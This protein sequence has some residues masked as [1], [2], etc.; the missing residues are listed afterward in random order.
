[1]ER[2]GLVASIE[3]QLER[4][5]GAGLLPKDGKLAS[6]QKMARV[7]GVSRTTIREALGRLAAR[8]LVVRRAGRRTRAVAL[9]EAVTL[10]NLG[11]ALHGEGRAHPDRRRLLE[12][13][14]ALKREA[15]VELLAACR[16]DA[17]RFELQGLT[18][19]CFAL[20]DAAR[21]EE[22]WVARE[23][24]LLRLAARVA[25]RPGH[26][27]LIQSLERA[28]WG[29]RVRVRPHLDAQAVSQWA[30]RALQA[31][32]E[33]EPA[34]LRRELEPLLRACDE[35][36]LERLAPAH[37]V[38]DRPGVS[39]TA[40]AERSHVETESAR[41]ALPGADCANLSACR[42]GSCAVAPEEV[43]RPGTAPTSACPE[44]EPGLFEACGPAA[45][46]REECVPAVS[47]S[48][49][50]VPG[51]GAPAWRDGPR[52]PSCPIDTGGGGDLPAVGT[53]LTDIAEAG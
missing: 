46:T 28:W 2:L 22:D 51:V 33:A 19:A 11:V 41:E 31:L 38:D 13:Y 29:I 52:G 26:L 47:A 15:M 10:E 17:S 24:E 9:D 53:A 49:S 43:S 1:M 44:P 12:G 27:L 7:Y 40:A 45:G 39:Q 32:D 8:G 16:E 18:D 48:H 20:M 6:E 14:F 36:V 5:I 3:E 42:T 35:R 50:P 23:F 30:Y 4:E 37:E 21:W 34:A 25:R